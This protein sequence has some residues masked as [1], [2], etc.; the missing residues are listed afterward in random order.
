LTTQ[1]IQANQKIENLRAQ[2]IH[3]EKRESKTF[4]LNEL[5]EAEA[6]EKL[7]TVE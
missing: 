7:K 6:G 1:I 3:M 5:K 4:N 2:L